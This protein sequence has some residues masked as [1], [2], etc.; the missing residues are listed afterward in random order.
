MRAQPN[1]S[2]LTPV[3]AEVAS[4]QARLREA[5]FDGIKEQDVKD[6]VASLVQRAKDGDAQATRMVFEYLLGGARGASTVNNVQINAPLPASPTRH[7]GGTR[8][9]L[10]VLAARAA[11][12][13]QLFRDDDGDG[14]D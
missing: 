9:K 8:G 13:E 3:N 12:G 2:Q 7:R 10:S 14:D 6:I 1:L 5:M 4:W 11:N